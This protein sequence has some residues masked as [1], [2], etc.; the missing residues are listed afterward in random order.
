MKKWLLLSLLAATACGGAQNADVRTVKHSEVNVDPDGLEL[1]DLGWVDVADLEPAEDEEAD[2]I[3][4]EE[5]GV[6]PEA[7]RV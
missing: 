1:G 5:D 7:P 2:A 6:A 4:G 3:A